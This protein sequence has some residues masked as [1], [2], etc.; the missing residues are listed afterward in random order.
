[1]NVLASVERSIVDAPD[2]YKTAPVNMSDPGN[3]P[4]F[5]SHYSRRNVRGDGHCCLRAVALCLFG[6]E[7]YHLFL[8][9]VSI[10][11]VLQAPVYWKEMFAG[12][13]TV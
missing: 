4:D 13:G 5:Y 10:A 8:R 11:V 3:H 2:P 1:M 12:Y 9:L 7:N 6:N